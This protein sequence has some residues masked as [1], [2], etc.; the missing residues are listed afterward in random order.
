MKLTKLYLRNIIKEELS[1]VLREDALLAEGH[2]IS[3]DRWDDRSDTGRTRETWAG[4]DA[5]VTVLAN[6]LSEEHPRLRI[7][8]S[9]SAYQELSALEPYKEEL[10]GILDWADLK[11]EARIWEV[12][13]EDIISAVRSL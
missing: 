8:S 12:S 13:V 10:K 5:V 7:H 6:Y 3:A 1:R 4:D 2:G 11:D 9:D